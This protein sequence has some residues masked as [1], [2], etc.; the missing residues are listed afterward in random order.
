MKRGM[1][2]VKHK[3]YEIVHCPACNRPME[4][5]WLQRHIK[6]AHDQ[7]L[8]SIEKDAIRDSVVDRGYYG[9][10][11]FQWEQRESP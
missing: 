8:S 10:G 1:F 6:R 11:Q 7:S 3:D 2:H 4:G 9:W 5:N